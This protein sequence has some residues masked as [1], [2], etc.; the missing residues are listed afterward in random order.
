M[1]LARNE[2]AKSLSENRKNRGHP[3]KIKTVGILRVPFTWNISN[4]S[5]VYGTTERACYPPRDRINKIHL[6]GAVP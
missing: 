6:V 5:D 2:L 4:S 3:T 1:L